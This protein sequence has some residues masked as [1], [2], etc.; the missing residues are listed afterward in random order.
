MY[1]LMI[2]WPIAAAKAEQAEHGT[3]EFLIH[4]MLFAH[5][6]VLH[7]RFVR[8]QSLFAAI[9]EICMEWQMAHNFESRQHQPRQ[10]KVNE[11]AFEQF[12]AMAHKQIHERFPT[13]FVA[14]IEIKSR[15]RWQNTGAIEYQF[16]PLDPIRVGVNMLFN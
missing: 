12:K 11:R 3:S 6:Q 5:S 14:K 4:F 16:Q 7:D 10:R 1:K 13:N 2:Y 9:Q 15:L 8:R